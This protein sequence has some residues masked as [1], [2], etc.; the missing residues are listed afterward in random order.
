[1]SDDEAQGDQKTDED[2]YAAELADED[3]DYDGTVAKKAKVAAKPAWCLV[4]TLTFDEVEKVKKAMRGKEKRVL[5]LEQEL[6]DLTA[7]REDLKALQQVAAKEKELER[8]LEKEMEERDLEGERVKKA[9]MICRGMMARCGLNVAMM[10]GAAGAG[11]AGADP[12]GGGE[13][14]GV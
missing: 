4:V 3:D 5:A 14:P 10:G 8:E 7:E 11:E 6:T 9:A 12:G 13:G 2:A 1:M